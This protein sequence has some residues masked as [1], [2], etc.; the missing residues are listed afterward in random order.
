MGT[1]AVATLRLSAP[2]K[3]NGTRPNKTPSA[4]ESSAVHRVGPGIII[5]RSDSAASTEMSSAR[6]TE[7]NPPSSMSTSIAP[8][9]VL[10]APADVHTDHPGAVWPRKLS[11]R[12]AATGRRVVVA[13]TVVGFGA[14]VVGLRATVVT[15]RFFEVRDVAASVV[16]HPKTATNGPRE[17]AAHNR[18]PRAIFLISHRIRGGRLRHLTQFCTRIMRRGEARAASMRR[19]RR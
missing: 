19:G 1:V 17:N 9:V 7:T 3:V 12:T 13:A 2:P 16:V 15:D 4:F 11:E 18:K 14:L 6:D 10:G 8:P 5:T